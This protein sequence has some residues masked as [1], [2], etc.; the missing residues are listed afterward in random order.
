MMSFLLPSWGKAK[1]GFSPKGS[2]K[3]PAKSADCEIQ[4]FQD[5][6]PDRPFAELGVINYH[7]EKHRTK[8]GNLKLEVA[9][10]LIK[11]RACQAG[12]D[13]IMNVHVTQVKHLEWAM[14]HVSAT[15]IRFEPK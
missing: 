15:A 5:L 4:V 3:Y 2:G 12:A 13:A 14:F 9:L 6:K 11:A 8:A 10:P 1:I 7:D